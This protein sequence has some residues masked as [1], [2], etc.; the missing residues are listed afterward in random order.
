MEESKLQ[1]ILNR[2]GLICFLLF[3]AL[4]VVMVIRNGSFGGDILSDGKRLTFAHWQ[5]EDGFREGYADAIKEYERI[6][7]K[8]GIK[9]RVVQTTVPVRGYPQWFLTQLI[10]GDCADVIELSGSEEIHNQYFLPLSRYLAAPN[11]Y[12]KGTPLEGMAWRD[13]FAD[14]MVSA[15][16]QTYSEYF[17]VST[18]MTTTRMYVNVD[19]YEKTTGEKKMPE[20]LDEWILACQKIQEYGEKIGRPLIPIGVRGFDKGTIAQIFTHFNNII[21]A[22]YN[23]SVSDYGYGPTIYEIYHK[24]AIGDKNIDLDRFLAPVEIVA[25]VGKYFAKGFSAIDLEQT[26]FLFNS[27]TVGFFIDG[28]Y[29]AFSMVNNSDFRVDII[30]LPLIG[31]NGKYRDLGRMTEVGGGVGGRFGIP[32]NARDIELALDFL[33]FI[34]SYK[35]SQLTMVRHSKWGSPLKQVNYREAFGPEISA[36]C[37]CKNK[38]EMT[39]KQIEEE[40]SLLEKC[41]PYEGLGYTGIA[42]IYAIGGKTQKDHVLTLED[43][44]IHQPENP[45]KF[46][47]N[48][49]LSRRHDLLQELDETI[50]SEKRTLWNLD[51]MRATFAVAELQTASPQEKEAYDNRY[52]LNMEGM[53]NRF[54][55]LE[56]LYQVIEDIPNLKEIE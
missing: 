8:E 18:F 4:S 44:I 3:F 22:D 28:T 7:A 9:V 12:N 24:L 41:R 6:K 2:I 42:N 27:G 14:D 32:K 5:L 20:T 13:T 35:I 49:I 50:I 30:P 39:K 51:G 52:K 15:L 1:Y 36:M 16:S 54:Q 19:L 31:P 55:Q 40:V 47:W 25:E 56:T 33:Q 23:D 29:N 38:K 45:K 26:K 11:P 46:F 17:G 43:I 37:H 48:S 53:I 21:N 10:G 34:T